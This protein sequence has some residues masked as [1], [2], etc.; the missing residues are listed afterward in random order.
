MLQAGEWLRLVDMEARYG[1]TRFEV[2]AALTKLAAVRMLEH[3]PNRGY[4]VNT[5]S[6]EEL[7]RR[8]E[9]R[10]LLELPLC[11]LI[12]HRATQADCD[13]LMQLAQHFAW[14]VENVG[15][16]ELDAANHAFHRALVQLCGNPD[17][18]RLVNELRERINPRGW[19]QWKTVSHSRQSAADHL[20]MVD[21]LNR[22]D[23]DL[24]RRIVRVHILRIGPPPR[25]EFLDTL[26]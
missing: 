8:V 5:V 7:A 6:D 4:R 24:L 18:A 2:R 20:A 12:I 21:A 15:V 26:P 16:A 23:A 13:R 22:R 25:A 17:L 10:L 9:I 19:T 11:P 14:A 3:V 1:A